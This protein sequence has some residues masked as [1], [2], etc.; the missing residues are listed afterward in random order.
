MSSSSYC[1]RQPRL[2]RKPTRK[3]FAESLEHRY[4]LTSGVP[5][6]PVL[7]LDSSLGIM[8]QLAPAFSDN[9]QLRPNEAKPSLVLPNY[10]LEVRYLT[11]VSER[12][13]EWSSFWYGSELM[14]LPSAVYIEFIPENSSMNRG[15]V[16]LLT[17]LR[18]NSHRSLQPI[19]P[20]IGLQL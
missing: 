13:M 3:P 2:T 19:R 14:S 11:L 4:L 9:P 20:N 17:S 7:D 12:Q 1:R 6:T 5:G 16:E 10:R 18:S 15:R 8:L